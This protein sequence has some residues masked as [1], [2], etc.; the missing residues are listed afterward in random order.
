MQIGYLNIIVSLSLFVVEEKGFF[1]AEGVRVQSMPVATSQLLTD[2]MVAGR[3][4]VIPNAN[5]V[6]ILAA[7]LQA[8]GKMKVFSTSDI[9]REAPFDAV[10]VKESSGL[11]GLADLAG[12]KISVH[13]GSAAALLR[14][15]LGD[16]GIDTSAITF[17]PM[18]PQEQLSA[19]REGSVDAIHT[20]E[21]TVA[22]VLT[23]GGFR[24]LYGSI[25][26]EMLSP[27]PQ[28]ASA[29]GDEDNSSLGTGHALYEGKRRRSAHRGFWP[30]AYGRGYSRSEGTGG[31]A[32]LHGPRAILRQGRIDPKRPVF[33]RLG[34]I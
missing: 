15:Y 12:K 23:A 17:V 2:G 7:E 32:C 27:S 25:F 10:L 8:P 11:K 4:D 1:K 21:P 3:I 16:Q 6:P 34:P 18:S 14:K 26:A 20:L 30:R 33:P 13:P 28:G 31:H 22:I 24:R 9:I 5:T 29:R 19:G